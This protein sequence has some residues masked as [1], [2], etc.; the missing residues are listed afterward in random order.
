MTGSNDHG[1][2][3]KSHARTELLK[4]TTWEWQETELFPGGWYHSGAA[5]FFDGAFYVTG[6]VHEKFPNFGNILKFIVKTKQWESLKTGVN[7]HSSSAQKSVILRLK[8]PRFKQSMI[9]MNKKLGIS[10]KLY[11]IKRQKRPC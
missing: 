8:I 4:L 1:S 7:P 10:S 11:L 2:Q 9:L 6:G 5:L 3:I